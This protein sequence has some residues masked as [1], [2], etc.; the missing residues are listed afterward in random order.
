MSATPALIEVD[1]D[2]EVDD[3]PSGG[4]EGKDE[5]VE[6]WGEVISSTS[7]HVHTP[8]HSPVPIY[9]NHTVPSLWAVL[10][11]RQSCRLPLPPARAILAVCGSFSAFIL[12]Q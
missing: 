6:S 10:S 8:S 9:L 3:Q 1:E 4:D 2:G 11:Y 12:P 5:K 7:T